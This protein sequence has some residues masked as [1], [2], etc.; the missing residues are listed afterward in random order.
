MKRRHNAVGL[1][2]IFDIAPGLA[3]IGFFYLN[4]IMS[5]IRIFL[6]YCSYN[7]LNYVNNLAEQVSNQASSS[8]SLP[9]RQ[10][11]MFDVAIPFVVEL[12]LS[13]SYIL[14]P[15]FHHHPV[16]HHLSWSSS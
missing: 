6:G 5:Y 9:T 12:V 1:Q 16:Q 2:L 7:C 11:Q 10:V 14:P 13:A 3:K 8:G 15:S 4:H